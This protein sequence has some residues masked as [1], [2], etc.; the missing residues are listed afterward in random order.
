MASLAKAEPI[1]NEFD[2]DAEL[3]EWLD[4]EAAE[5]GIDPRDLRQ[6]ET[7]VWERWRRDQNPEDFS[8]L[9]NSHQPLLYRSTERIV[10]STTLPKEA[11]RSRVLRNYVKAL[12]TFD[13]TKGTQLSSYVYGKAGEHLGRYIQR[14]TNVGRIPEDR[15]GLID[16]MQNREAALRDQMGRPPSDTELADDMLLASQDLPEIRA[17]RISAKAVGTLRRELRRDLLAEEAGGEGGSTGDSLL[18]QQ[19]V[20]LHGSL[21]PEQQ[22]VLEHTYSG[23]G[24]PVTIDPIELSKQIQLSP[25]KIRAIKKQIAN[26]LK[27]YY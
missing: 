11:V 15:A 24:K 10:R 5:Q 23:F 7:E 2:L 22:L 17:S 9:Y 12:D 16:L 13:P 21:N 25:Q 27:R 26:K 8:W 1:D 20:F 19:A 3:D 18:E 14:Y 4:K 6:M